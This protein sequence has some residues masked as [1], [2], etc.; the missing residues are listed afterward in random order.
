MLFSSAAILVRTA[1]I[2]L[3]ENQIRDDTM[4]RCRTHYLVVLHVNLPFI[5]DLLGALD[6]KH[7]CLLSLYV[8]TTLCLYHVDVGVTVQL[9]F[10]LNYITVKCPKWT[11]H[12]L[13]LLFSLT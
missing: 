9:C 13:L 8:C 5:S 6:F 3:I 7:S 11:R 4:Q 12:I 10:H 1:C 2:S